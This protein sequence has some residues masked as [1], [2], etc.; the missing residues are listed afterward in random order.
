[1]H[2]TRTRD[3][4]HAFKWELTVHLNAAGAQKFAKKFSHQN[5]MRSDSSA[6]YSS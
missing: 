5:P 1:M 3:K 4:F 6:Q 2:V